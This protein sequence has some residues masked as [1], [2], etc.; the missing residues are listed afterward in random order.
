MSDYDFASEINKI[1]KEKWHA[2]ELEKP[3]QTDDNE[4]RQYDDIELDEV[5]SNPQAIYIR[6]GMP[7]LVTFIDHI[8]EHFA[9][10]PV[11][12]SPFT[13]VM[14]FIMG[15]FEP[16]GRMMT[17][18]ELKY[19]DEAFIIH[20]ELSNLSHEDNMK[21]SNLIKTVAADYMKL[22]GKKKHWFVKDR[23]YNL[24]PYQKYIMVVTVIAK[25]IEIEPWIHDAFW[26]YQEFEDI[27]QDD[28]DID[29]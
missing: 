8:R 21:R 2:L 29:E 4:L 27:V 14:Q 13:G 15:N 26:A 11:D 17:Y 12:V 28:D 19:E 20:D 23:Y 10:Q 1:V 7:Y 5:Y 25:M 16:F 22:M 3:T 24:N 18:M 9:Y 6:V